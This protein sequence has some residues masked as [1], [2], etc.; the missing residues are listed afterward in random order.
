[1]PSNTAP[2]PGSPLAA[3][4]R[5]DD[6]IASPQ[7]GVSDVQ[8]AIDA[9]KASSGGT[10]VPGGTI[11][12]PGSGSLVFVPPAGTTVYRATFVARVASAGGSGEADGDSYMTTGVLAFNN[13]AGT[14]TVVPATVALW[15][16]ATTASMTDTT[17]GPASGGAD[18][19]VPFTLPAGLDAG[20]ETN[21]TGTFVLL[22]G[23]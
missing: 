17:F 6:F 19:S 3:F 9:L 1:M 14:I 18:V 16:I 2:L 10:V 13:L 23:A 11:V 4:I 8:D 5:Y 12:G 7:L 20:T 15:N 21:V 22:G